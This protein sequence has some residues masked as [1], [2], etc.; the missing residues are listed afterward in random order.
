[1]LNTITIKNTPPHTTTTTEGNS[2]KNAKADKK[3]SR[4]PDTESISTI[5]T[6]SSTD[7]EGNWWEK[8]DN[9]KP[10]PPPP[11]TELH[12]P[13][14]SESTSVDDPVQISGVTGRS[15]PFDDFSSSIA[16]ALFDNSKRRS[17]P[18][19]A[20]ALANMS[21]DICKTIGEEL[22]PPLIPTSSSGNTTSILS[23]ALQRN[24]GSNNSNTLGVSYTQPSCSAS[25]PNVS[26]IHTN[27]AP[28]STSAGN[29]PVMSQRSTQALGV[30]R[31][32]HK[33]PA[34]LAT[35]IEPTQNAHRTEVQ[36]TLSN[37]S[38]NK[39]PPPPKPQPYSGGAV[40]FYREKQQ[41]WAEN[42]AKGLNVNGNNAYDP[43]GELF[44]DG[45]LQAYAKGTGNSTTNCAQP[46]QSKESPL[47]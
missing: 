15:S 36:K 32:S 8:Q 18:F 39:R 33:D 47:V 16:Q 11:R 27:S 41:K 5:S 10:P 19:A 13:F 35:T 9:D 30:T 3:D 6:C 17:D 20:S 37:P 29:S 7:E 21:R 43:F 4:D 40:H 45:G 44:G 1:M 28:K 12:S 25:T 42:S 22:P 26:I 31:N 23:T 46:V 24:S 2:T 34:T 14:P 38:S